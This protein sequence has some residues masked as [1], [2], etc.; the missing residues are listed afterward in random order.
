MRRRSSL[1]IVYPT[2]DYTSWQLITEQLRP[3]LTR[4]PEQ[5][6]DRKASESESG[7]GDLS[8]LQLGPVSFHGDRNAVP[9]LRLFLPLRSDSVRC[10]MFLVGLLSSHFI[11]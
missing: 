9:E 8:P 7:L 11:G 6:F 4:R 1:F 5:A 2:S 10:F 3:K